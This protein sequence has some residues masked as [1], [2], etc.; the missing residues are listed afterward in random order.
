MR[1]HAEISTNLSVADVEITDS[2][3]TEAHLV[4]P[5][6]SGATM[7]TM[8]VSPPR[9]LTDEERAQMRRWLEMWRKTGPVLEEERIHRM[10]A[11]TELEAARIACDL[12][13]LARPGGGD[14]PKGC[15][16]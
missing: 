3:D 9:P 2:R 13:L 10:Q 1:S 14:V 7:H 12:W 6:D 4:A 5:I 15:C 16:R 11:L 8:S